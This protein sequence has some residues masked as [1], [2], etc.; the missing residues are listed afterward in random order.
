MSGTANHRDGFKSASDSRY[1]DDFQLALHE[2]GVPANPSDTKSLPNDSNTFAARTGAQGKLSGYW[3]QEAQYPQLPS[4]V[5]D[6]TETME[7]N[8]R[9]ATTASP[10][11]PARATAA[12]TRQRIS[13]GVLLK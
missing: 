1:V 3:Q 5:G 9:D 6:G 11:I 4:P 7:L 10:R 2:P 8:R 13:S 12:S